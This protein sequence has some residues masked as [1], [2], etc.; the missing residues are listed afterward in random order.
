MFI[1]A[2]TGPSPLQRVLQ[3]LGPEKSNHHRG[4]LSRI[5]RHISEGQYQLALD[6]LRGPTVGLETGNLKAVLLMRLG[7]CQEAVHLLRPLVFDTN[8]LTLK[9]GIPDHVVLNF[10]TSLLLS[11]NVSGCREMLASIKDPS[12]EGVQLIRGRIQLWEKSLSLLKWLD[13]KIFGIEH[14]SGPFP[15]DFVPGV[16]DWEARAT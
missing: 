5:V 15:I 12:H 10:A 6:Q 3:T 9:S 4:D 2:D 11:G 7:R 14:V 1:D 8:N 13:L 16:F